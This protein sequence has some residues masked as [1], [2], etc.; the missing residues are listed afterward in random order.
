MKPVHLLS[1]LALA[2]G[3]PASLAPGI[4][5]AAT[6]IVNPGDSI[7]AA[8]DAA[9]AG[10]T[11]KV[12]P[13]DYTEPAATAGAAVHITKPLKL[14]AASKLKK[15][16]KV[17]I[18]PGPGQSSGIVVEPANVSDPDIVGVTIAGFTVEGFSN[19]GIWLKHVKKYK[20]EGNES[21]NNLE[22]GIWPTLSAKGSVKKNVAY[23][24]LDA[25]L[26]V[27]ASEDVRVLGNELA[28]SPTGLEIT[29]SKKVKV[30]KNDI[31][32]TVVGVG[33]YH[34][35]AAG[36][37]PVGGDGD[38]VIK[39][40]RIYNNNLPNNAPPW[41]MPAALPSGVGVLIL[42][43]DRVTLEKNVIE[44]HDFVGVAILDWC[45]AVDGSGFDCGSNP[46]VTQSAPDNNMIRR[47]SLG[48]NG[49]NPPGGIFAALAGD[50]GMVAFPNP[51]Y[52]P[53][54]GHF[55]CIKDNIPLPPQSALTLNH[56]GLNWIECP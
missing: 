54:G 44:N 56:M 16:I 43:V 52:A 14:I 32:D 48:G 2:I 38:W 17:R 36:L 24:S 18:L 8:V 9:N 55:N 13:G 45:I 6:H 31:H 12:M 1:A 47:N 39:S 41:S 51:P 35:N 28:T 5:E 21:I 53:N 7:Q 20:I 19:N 25:A 27:E 42:G 49:G 26:W 46:P 11:V 10:D 29:V 15:G 23:G 40:N 37:P 33:L 3:L 50:I 34:P 22:V 4:A 30:Q